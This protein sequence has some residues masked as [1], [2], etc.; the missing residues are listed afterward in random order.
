[1]NSC[2]K[3]TFYVPST[4]PRI[5]LTAEAQPSLRNS[6]KE[7]AWV[8]IG[9]QQFLELHDIDMNDSILPSHADVKS[10]LYHG[11]QVSDVER[12]DV[13]LDSRFVLLCKI[14]LFVVQELSS[15]NHPIRGDDSLAL[16][17]V[18]SWFP[19][20][21]WSQN[22]RGALYSLCMYC[23]LFLDCSLSRE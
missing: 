3:A 15:R 10:C 12:R 9:S 21:D 16:W 7:G 19:L 5:R 4:L 18:P 11:V 23:I 1:M 14:G 20:R 8:S 17:R 22:D 13:G 2:Q 6:T